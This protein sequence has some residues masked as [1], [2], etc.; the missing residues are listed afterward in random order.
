MFGHVGK[1]INEEE[2]ALIKLKRRLHEV[3]DTHIST[4]HDF[5]ENSLKYFVS[6]L[7][8]ERMIQLA[9][10]Y[11][12]FFSTV[13]AKI[14]RNNENITRLENIHFPYGQDD[15]YCSKDAFRMMATDFLTLQSQN[16]SDDTKVAIFEQIYLV[17]SCSYTL[18]GTTETK[19][20][21]E[22]RMQENKKKLESV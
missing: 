4:T 16:L 6:Q 21:K 20:A 2:K 14:D 1:A 15:I 12:I 9:D 10:N 22:R 3:C 13:V 17:Q 5:I 7:V 8:L 18:T 11:T 19:A